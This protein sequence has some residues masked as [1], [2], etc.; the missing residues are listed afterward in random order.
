MKPLLKWSTLA[1]ALALPVSA[2][3]HRAW[4]LPSATVLSGNDAWV[5]VDAA[6]SNGL[7]NFEHQP[8][9]LDNLVVTAPDGS[10]VNP[11]N[12]STGKY[13]STFDVH[14]ANPGTYKL[15]VVSDGVSASYKDKGERKRW[16]G[17]AENL[18][19]EIPAGAED[20]KVTQNLRRLETFVTAGKPN[21]VALKP[22]GQGLELIPVTHPNDLFAKSTATFILH[23]D[24]TPAADLKVAIARG[25]ERYRTKPEE[26]TATTDKD[27]KFAVTWAEPGMYWIEAE[28]TDGKA[29]VK[30][31]K[32][33]RLTYA[34]T[35][36]VLPE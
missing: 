10:T 12:P 5:S 26:Q 23:I 20:L 21:D 34:A 32:E 17:K 1:L 18:A 16:R 7:F 2:H 25:G 33:R 19:S 35:F 8:L 3:A 29:T 11:Q 31:A 13:R 6:V 36:E 15:A 14:L 22:S 30:E 4:L 27:G 9:R 28:A 24:G